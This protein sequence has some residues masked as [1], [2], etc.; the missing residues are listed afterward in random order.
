M[1]PR[2][3]SENPLRV[4][5]I[6]SGPAGFYTAEHLFRRSDLVARVD[7]FERLPMPFGLVRFG[8][9]PD[10]QKI[11]NVTKAFD[12]VASRAEFRF[13][14]NVDFGTDVTL[15]D[16][17]HHYDVICFTTGAQTD[18]SMGIPGEDLARSHPATEF[19]AWYNGHP[20]FRGCVFDLSAERVA[21]VGVGNVA[22]DVARI[23]CRTTEELARTD[24]ADYALDA[25]RA[26]RVKEVF[27]LGRRGPAQAAFT[28]AELKELGELGGADLIARESE[29][30]LDPLSQADVQHADDRAIVAKVELLQRFARAAPTGK[31]RRL[32][33][34][35]LVSPTELI[36]DAVGRVDGMRLVRNALHR[37]D[38]GSLRPRPT[39]E[40][41][42]LQV[43]M[44]FRSV[45]YRGVAL[46][47]VPFDD[48]R[49]VVPNE[50]GR[51]L[52]GEAGAPM[53]GLYVAGW[54][55]RG[56][57][58]IIGTNKSD[59]GDTVKSMLDDVAKGAVLR[60]TS[61]D[62]AAIEQLVRER[63]PEAL[64]YA[65]WRK[66]DALEVERGK[67]TGRPRVKL[68][69]RAEALGLLRQP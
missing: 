62:P 11:K 19:V 20:H 8:V 54:I 36:G 48:R 23:L 12:R 16:L 9:A 40:V 35:F 15:D 24:I 52:T 55:K 56:P 51:I 57:T 3:T 31:P 27:M 58:G 17:R 33:I 7:M 29:V 42:E 68:T 13:F 32:E 60:P 63:Q 49:G 30:E 44:V 50:R 66:L 37:S 14:G 69:S 26:S 22:V 4:A 45:G 5:I 59:A 6:G 2:G 65:D 64:S 25:L 34:R 38:D 61:R 41:E 21:I 53:P 28:N 18:R 10:H 1:I 47:G 67:A 46:P 39:D 43:G